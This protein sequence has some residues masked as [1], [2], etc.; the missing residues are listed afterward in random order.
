MEIL[1]FKRMVNAQVL[2]LAANV[3]HQHGISVN[4]RFDNSSEGF[5]QLMKQPAV[6]RLVFGIFPHWIAINFGL[7]TILIYVGNPPPETSIVESLYPKNMISSNTTQLT[8]IP[9]QQ[10]QMSDG[11][12]RNDGY[13]PNSQMSGYGGYRASQQPPTPVSVGRTVSP[14]TPQFPRKVI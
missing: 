1:A 9:Q 12:G 7:K 11:R 8:Q 4:I 10:Q 2:Q 14:A 5:E 13:L 6:G 3:P